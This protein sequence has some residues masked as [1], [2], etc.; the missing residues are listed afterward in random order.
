MTRLRKQPKIFTYKLS[1]RQTTLLT[2][3]KSP[4]KSNST[5]LVINNKLLYSIPCECGRENVGEMGRTLSQRMT[6][7]K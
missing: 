3:G 1:S 7:H 4:G 2:K 5:K 6:E